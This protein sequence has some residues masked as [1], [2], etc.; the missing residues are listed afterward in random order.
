MGKSNSML[1]SKE[2][3]FDK[4]KRHPSYSQKQKGVSE[5][6]FQLLFIDNRASLFVVDEKKRELKVDYQSFRGLTRDILKTIEMLKAKQRFSIK[7]GKTDQGTD[8]TENGFLIWQLKRSNRFVDENLTPIEIEN[9][10]VELTLMIKGNTQLECGLFIPKA[11]ISSEKPRFVNEN[12]VLCGRTLYTIKPTG[13]DY[14]LIVSF[15]TLILRSELQTYQSLFF[16]YC[17][18]VTVKFNEFSVI[19]GSTKTSGVA[20][21]F[22]KVTRQ[23][24]L[25]LKICSSLPGFEPGFLDNYDLSR[26]AFVD[27]SEK[28]ITVHELIQ[29]DI[30]ST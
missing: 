20:L 15:E 30:F 7:W 29:G 12:H 21:V 3:L 1:N 2:S 18:N 24:T 23:N 11:E 26:V 6:F 9:N 13:A 14:S 19:T 28:T 25:Y 10:P 8:L 17:E 16:S 22:E 4:L 5:V 27:E